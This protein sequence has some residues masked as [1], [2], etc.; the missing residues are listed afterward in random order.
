[1][2][3]GPLVN[4]IE[5]IFLKMTKN[6]KTGTNQPS[7]KGVPHSKQTLHHEQLAEENV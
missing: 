5:V 2:G 4:Q 1:M 6:A 7:Q 3:L